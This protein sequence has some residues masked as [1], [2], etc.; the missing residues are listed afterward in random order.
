[1]E[2]I[3]QLLADPDLTVQATAI[4]TLITINAPDTVRYL[5]ETLQ[6]E[7]E[8]VRRAAV[9]VLNEIGDERAI[10]DLLNA[11]KD[12]DW[13]VK[14]RAA[15]ALGSIGGPRVLDAVLVLIKDDDEFLRRTAV[16]ILN[17]SK[18]LKAFDKLVEALDDNDWWV[19]E[20]A[21]DALAALGDTRA[22]KPLMRMLERYPE[23]ALVVVR[24]LATLGDTK[25]VMPI[26]KQLRDGNEA[27]IKESLL[28][29]NKLT[30]R[31]HI[32]DVQGAITQLLQT[33][34]S[35]QVNELATDTFNHITQRF[36]IDTSKN[37]SLLM[38]Y[39][40]H[41]TVNKQSQ[42]EKKA[43]PK[44]QSQQIIDAAQLQAGE[45]FNDRYR[46]VKQVGKG[47]FGV[48]VLVEDIVVQDQFI[49][50]FLNPQVASDEISIR[51]FT[52]ELRYARKITHPNVIRIYD[53]ITQGKNYAI[54][55]EYFPSHSLTRII[56]GDKTVDFNAGIHL[57]K[58]VCGGMAAAQSVNVVHRDL[59][60]G[61][62]L[63]NDKRFVKIVDF[64][65]AAAATQ[66][67][68]RL[69]K[70]GILVGTPTYMA[71]EQVRGKAIDPRTDIYALGIIM[72]EMFAG[73]TPYS[74]DDSMSI[75][76][77]HVEGQAKPPKEV[78]PAI[79]ETLQNIILKAMRIE[80]EQRY[81]TFVELSA[82]LESLMETQH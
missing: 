53:F 28:A 3:C 34:K 65:L 12:A 66:V 63:V 72:Y 49:L 73:K 52:H 43:R 69:T 71:P 57:L 81:Q 22:V 24:A 45:L 74:G 59:K 61:N 76:F 33:H 80:P 67:D 37:D 26:L 47:A 44:P 15:D 7:S 18:D 51:R 32:V 42:P 46:I 55:M 54:S 27:L 41:P 58:Q 30:D 13:W 36:G 4:E 25:A 77:Q 23:G 39:E 35:K 38:H 21:V 8:Y 64:G 40:N 50:K 62:I 9:E 5:I 60:P 70:T 75:M 10:K 14:V 79:P 31:E 29:L 19:R 6:D 78:N 11:L 20:R 16:E 17:T 48:V 82:D 1:V 56:N 68:S 2:V